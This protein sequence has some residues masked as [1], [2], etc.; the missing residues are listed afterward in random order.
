MSIILR[1]LLIVLSVV[2]LLYCAKKIRKSKM[3]TDYSLFWIFFSGLLFLTSIVPQIT[4]WISSLLGI[5]SP[6]NFI[7]LSIIFLLLFHS[8]Y[9]TLKI[10]RVEDILESLV[11]DI[12]IKS[13]NQS[14]EKNK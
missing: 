2:S 1:I 5:D 12:S 6:A 8:F 3:K 9:L 4:I 10:S 11:S 14:D 7:F 13:V